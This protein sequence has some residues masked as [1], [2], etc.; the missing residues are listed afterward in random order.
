VKKGMER[1]TSASA[2]SARDLDRKSDRIGIVSFG[3]G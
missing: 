2:G 3:L 1:V